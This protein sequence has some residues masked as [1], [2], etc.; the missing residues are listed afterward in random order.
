MKTKELFEKKK[1]VMSAEVF[2]P[3]KSGTMEG[4][5]RA[6]KELTAISPDFVSVTCGAGGDGGYST[7]DVASVALDAFG[8]EA[9]AHLTC[10]GLTKDGLCREVEILDRKNIQNILVLRGD[11]TETGVLSDF[12]YADELALYIKKNYPQ[13]NLIGACYPECHI[14][15]PDLATDIDNLKRKVDSGVDHLITQLFFDNDAFYRFYDAVRAKGIDVPV[16]AGI[17]PVV[18]ASS[19]RRIV[20]M[21]GASLPARFSR[22]L[23]KYDGAALTDAGITYAAGQ[24]IDLVSNGVQGIHLYT[25]NNGAV[26]NKIFT[27]LGSIR[28]ALNE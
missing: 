5:I 28:S 8:L 7:T 20:Q 1:L 16:Q 27:A 17:M 2:P 22:I 10:V 14:E 25:M 21:C 12:M 23:A 4:V 26:A 13:F 11:K 24:I 18:N 19:I 3:K 9:V 15:A 6:L